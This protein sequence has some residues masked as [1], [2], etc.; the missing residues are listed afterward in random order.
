MIVPQFQTMQA[1]DNLD[2]LL[3]NLQL[4][5]GRQSALIDGFGI[6]FDNK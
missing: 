1:I 3:D 2:R 5:T 6:F 4:L